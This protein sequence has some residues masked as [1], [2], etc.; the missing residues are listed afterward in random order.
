MRSNIRL[1][2]LYLLGMML[3]NF[4]GNLGVKLRPLKRDSGTRLLW[5]GLT[6]IPGIFRNL[7]FFFWKVVLG[8]LHLVWGLVLAVIGGFLCLLF[9]YEKN[10]W[11]CDS[12]AMFRDGLDAM[13]EGAALFGDAGASLV[14]TKEFDELD[15]DRVR[16]RKKYYLSRLLS[17]TDQTS[18][19]PLNCQDYPEQAPYEVLAKN[20]AEAFQENVKLANL[21]IEINQI[22]L[23]LRQ[24][25]KETP[26]AVIDDN[27]R[28]QLYEESVDKFVDLTQRKV[29]IFRSRLKRS[30]CASVRSFNVKLDN[31]VNPDKWEGDQK[32]KYDKLKVDSKSA[33]N[34]TK[35]KADKDLAELMKKFDI[36]NEDFKKKTGDLLMAEFKEYNISKDDLSSQFTIDLIRTAMM[37]TNKDRL[38]E[39]K[40][41]S[42]ELASEAGKI[43]ELDKSL[44]KVNKVPLKDDSVQTVLVSSQSEG[45][46]DEQNK[47]QL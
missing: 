25:Y 36:K 14:S 21:Q 13:T 18:K 32:K 47:E 43:D 20:L 4:Y 17:Q 24:G 3:V 1:V 6:W 9:C 8:I 39:I 30:V 10:K 28:K 44:E 15:F 40:K 35:Q 11:R 42:Q 41:N 37:Q 45:E 29:V 16:Q 27:A 12:Y 26:S 19:A 33:D 23:Y 46:E 5:T 38:V 7:W 31:M 34:K 2:S 22:N